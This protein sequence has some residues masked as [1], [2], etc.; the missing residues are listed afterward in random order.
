MGANLDTITAYLRGKG[1]T[2]AQIA[3]VEGN[4]QVESG[5]DPNPAAY[6]PGEN[7]HGVAQWE[8]GRWAALQSFAAARGA[9]P[10]D[11]GTQLDFMWSELTGPE[12]GA[13]AALQA[14]TTPSAAA[15]AFDQQYER[16]SAASL[17]TRIANAQAIVGQVPAGGPAVQ[18]AGF[19]Q[20]VG[21]LPSGDTI[22]TIAYTAVGI[23]AA[24]ALVVLGVKETVKGHSA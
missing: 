3:G 12:S 15:A 11:L 19:A 1:L 24:G 8:G 16:S 18:P 14:A 10:T 2:A 20:N 21:L 9:R 6:N 4:L 13:L 17:P 5:A 23:A 22:K 7:A